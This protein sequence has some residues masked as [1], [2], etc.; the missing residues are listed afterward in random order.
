MHQAVQGSKATSVR[1]HAKNVDT[2]L[3]GLERLADTSPHVSSESSCSCNG[4]TTSPSKIV[5]EG[6]GNHIIACKCTK[7]L[8]RF[9]KWS[10]QKPVTSLQC[11]SAQIVAAIR[12]EMRCARTAAFA[13]SS[14][15]AFSTC[16]T[17]EMRAAPILKAR[18]GSPNHVFFFS[19]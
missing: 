12:Q 13:T 16:N 7:C 3:T 17:A 6:P 14:C 1:L 5:Q 11:A 19:F 10:C 8:G 2:T 18:K 15:T 9:R 4:F